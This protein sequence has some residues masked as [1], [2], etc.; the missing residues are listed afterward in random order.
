MHSPGRPGL[1]TEIS[2]LTARREQL[3]QAA[4]RPG[5]PLRQT[6]DAAFAGLD[7]A[8]DALAAVRHADQEEPRAVFEQAPVALFL[9]EQDGVVQRANRRAG[10][11]LGFPAGYATGKPFTALVDL[12]AR[13]AVHS[14]LTAA[15]RSGQARQIRCGLLGAAGPVRGM[16]D[17]SPAEVTGDFPQLI[18][19]VT[20]YGSLPGAPSQP[21]AAKPDPAHQ[22]PAAADGA[23]ARATATRLDVLGAATRLVL[24]SATV[25]E[26][27]ML[28]RCASLLAR[29]LAAWVIVDSER[30]RQLRRQF[31][32]G[33]RDEQSVRLARSLSGL[34]PQPESAP[35]QVHQS[36]SSLLVAHAEDA[37]LL[38]TDPDGV[39]ILD[40]LGA[41]SVLSVPLSDGERSYGTLTLAQEAGEGYFGLADIGVVEEIG[42]YLALAI[43]ADRS[44]RERADAAQVRQAGDRPTEPREPG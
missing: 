22:D 32:I 16:L 15:G 34:D 20:P 13:T 30:Q 38:G 29:E 28:Q 9:L 17:I 11:L 10:H 23:A 14:Q 3:R 21:Q 5:A 44:F 12:P 4:A 2:G 1:E 18:V 39:P 8:I 33:P 40:R 35:S 25:S 37:G 43:R 42:E 36:G 26:S 41:T 31:V 27:A 6:L 7:E 19:A 24:E